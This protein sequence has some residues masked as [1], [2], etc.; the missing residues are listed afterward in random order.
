MADSN[1]RWTPRWFLGLLHEWCDGPI[2]LDTCTHESNPTQAQRFYAPG[3]YD[4]LTDSWDPWGTEDLPRA[5]HPITWCNPPYGRGQLGKWSE[6]AVQEALDGVPILMLTPADSST[7]WFATLRK[8]ADAACLM[9]KRVGFV[10]P[11]GQPLPGAKFGSALWYWGRR[12]M[13]FHAFW[14]RRGWV[15]D[16]PGPQE[17]QR[18]AE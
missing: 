3:Y 18:A 9:S 2:A 11:D 16:C 12:C 8:N 5:R 4:G 10:M 15:I 1:E 13:A 14:E 7:G 17:V 6:K